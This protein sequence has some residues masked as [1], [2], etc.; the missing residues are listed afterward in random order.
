MWSSA[1]FSTRP[2][3]EKKR[4]ISYQFLKAMRKTTR[5]VQE[6]KIRDDNNIGNIIPIYRDY[7]R[8][9]KRWF[10]DIPLPDY[11]W[12]ENNIKEQKQLEE[13]IKMKKKFFQSGSKM[14]RKKISR[15]KPTKFF[16]RERKEAI[17]IQD[18][19]MRTN[20]AKYLTK[21]RSS[22]ASIWNQGRECM[23]YIFLLFSIFHDC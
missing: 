2:K 21:K 8:G 3:T 14:T 5:I 15:T 23:R 17:K 18:G 13:I 1:T 4:N 22:N 20:R 16:I 19:I 9:G 11:Y 7:Y 6:E 12:E 10:V